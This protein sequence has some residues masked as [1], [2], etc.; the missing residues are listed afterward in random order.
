M[1]TNS[2]N[3]VETVSDRLH[4]VI[5][6]S[7]LS[8]SE[9]AKR[10]GVSKSTL[11]RYRNG[12]GSIPVDF[13]AKV[14]QQFQIRPN[15]FIY[16]NGPPYVDLFFGSSTVFDVDQIKAFVSDVIKE[17][18]VPLTPEGYEKCSAMIRAMIWNK[19][20]SDIKRWLGEYLSA[21]PEW[22]LTTEKRRNSE[23]M[24]GRS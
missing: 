1:N 6:E 11:I 9:F 2:N 16:G 21:F 23:K 13:V 17:E 5:D 4:R 15:W 10:V 7:D 22:M 3:A 24:R 19:L 18:N 14:C 12:V 8:L 20:R